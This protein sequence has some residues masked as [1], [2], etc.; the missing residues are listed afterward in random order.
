MKKN[1]LLKPV[2]VFFVLLMLSMVFVPAACAQ[3]EQKTM[4]SPEDFVPAENVKI[5]KDDSESRIAAVE[6][7]DGSVLYAVSRNDPNVAGRVNFVLVAED[8]LVS[9][10]DLTADL[11]SNSAV[12][13]A[14]TKASAS[15]WYGSYVQTYGNSL[16]GGVQIHFSQ[17]DAQMVCAAGSASAPAIGAAIGSVVPGLGSSAGLL[18]G[19]SIA[20]LV[21]VYYW[22][23]QNM[24]GSLDVKVSYNSMNAIVFGIPGAGHFILFGRIYH[25]LK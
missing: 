17:R 13:A 9:K 5:L 14:V 11:R 2:S 20:V 4:F 22:R 3:A 19:T 18:I 10:G 8:D 1:N 7:K 16:T 25:Y 23:A 15:F 6:T 21:P 24:D 12:A